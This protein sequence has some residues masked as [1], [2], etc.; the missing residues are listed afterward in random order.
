MKGIYCYIDNK[1]D[2]IVYVGKDSKINKHNNRHYQHTRKCNYNHQ[3][4]N[5]I[6]QNNPSRYSYEVLF[7]GKGKYID[8]NL[9]QALYD[10]AISGPFDIISGDQKYKSIYGEIIGF[11]RKQR[12]EKGL[13]NGKPLWILFRDC[14]HGVLYRRTLFDDEQVRYGSTS[15]SEDSL[16][17]LKVGHKTN[18]MVFLEK[19]HPCYYRVQNLKSLTN[20]FSN[21]D[22]LNELIKGIHEILKY[23]EYETDTDDE[24]KY[25]IHKILYLLSIHRYVSSYG[26]D[27]HISHNFLKA[28]RKEAKSFPGIELIKDKNY[29]IKSLVDFEVN[30]IIGSMVLP[31]TIKDITYF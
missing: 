15:M 27:T 17:L 23:I 7:I 13:S 24:L 11:N 25:V 19:D 30:L 22:S 29:I 21:E 5:K 20:N 26:T 12:I 16:F 18:S 6:I 31:R 1:T 3:I 4:I 8:D 14:H 2:E 28:L 9:L 10:K